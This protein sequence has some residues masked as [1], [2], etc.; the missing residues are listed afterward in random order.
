MFALILLSY[1]SDYRRDHVEDQNK[2]RSVLNRMK[3]SPDWLMPGHELSLLACH[4]SV[5]RLRRVCVQ[6]RIHCD[7]ESVYSESKEIYTD[8]LQ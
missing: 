2:T 1:T 5:G 8:L 3:H 7:K 4:W 6:V